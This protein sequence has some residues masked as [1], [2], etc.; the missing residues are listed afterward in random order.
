MNSVKYRPE[1]DGLRAVAVLPV[2]LFHLGCAWMPGGYIGVDVFFVISG[3]LI[4][5]ILADEHLQGTFKYTNFWLRRV[6]R[7]FPALAA[8]LLATALVGGYLI[9]G[10]DANALGKT[11]LAALLSFANVALW[12]QTGNYWGADAENNPL[13]HTWS[14]S[15]EE[16]FYFFF[17]V[18]LA[19][20]F[21]FARKWVFASILAIALA[22]FALYVYAA[23]HH[24]AAGFYLLPTRAWELACGCLLAIAQRQHGWRPRGSRLP[25]LAGLAAILLSYAL[26]SGENALPGS[27]AFAVLGTVLVLAYANGPH[28]LAS[29]LLSWR[30]LVFVGK[31]SYSLYL[32]H[33]PVIVYANYH[34]F[35]GGA[36]PSPWMLS[37]IIGAASVASYYFVEKTTRHREKILPPALALFAACLALSVLIIFQRDPTDFSKFS[38]TLWQGRLYDATPSQK[39]WTGPMQKRMEGIQAPLRAE[40]WQEAYKSNGIFKAYNGPRADI[41]V[42]GDSH[43]LMWAPVLDEAARELKLSISFFTADGTSPFFR[44]PEDLKM[45][46]DWNRAELSAFDQARKDRIREWKPKLVF[47]LTR[48]SWTG[49]AAEELLAFLDQQGCQIVTL[50]EPPALFYGNKNTLR[51]LAAMGKYPRAVENQHVRQDF[52]TKYEQGRQWVE[53]L[54]RQHPHFQCLPTSDLL[55]RPGGLVWVLE[56]THALYIDDNHLSLDGALKGKARIK[57]A[58]ASCFQLATQPE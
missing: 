22:S 4:T 58:M 28:G 44:V 51:Q 35:N 26:I 8:M 57:A 45:L 48:W 1:I 49:A 14:L 34:Y 17:P 55:A 29:G 12:R 2:I 3:F 24:P 11:T 6:R 15:V 31:I 25:A 21:R 32:W 43:A 30:P 7:I 33:W 54:T 47:V 20:L 52:A 36:K 39:P 53:A 50:E 56:G 38:P 40:A 46:P 41:V 18:L 42:L 10:G 5:S 9:A 27:L 23:G 13:L 19:C 16:Q 37:A